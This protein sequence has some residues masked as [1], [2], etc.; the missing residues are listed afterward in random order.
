[1]DSPHRGSVAD[2]SNPSTPNSSQLYHESQWNLISTNTPSPLKQFSDMTTPSP[3]KQFS[4]MTPSPLKQFSDMTTPS[5]LKNFTVISRPVESSVAPDLS[6]CRRRKLFQD[7]IRH[8]T[9]KRGRPS[10]IKKIS[11]ACF[12]HPELCVRPRFCST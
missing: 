2:I 9:K 11:P 1:M 5:P 3:L 6:V 8:D 12:H 4:D 7:E 10:K